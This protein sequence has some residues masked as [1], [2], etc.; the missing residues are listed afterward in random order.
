LLLAR[1]V[2]ALMNH[3]T[4]VFLRIE[5]IFNE[6]LDAPAEVRP[7][8][9]AERCDGDATLMDEVKSLLKASE[10]EEHV[11]ASRRREPGFME[12]GLE[13]ETPLEQRRIGPYQLDR[14]LGRGGMG[15]V[16]LAHRVDGQFEQKVAIKLIDL[17]LATDFFRERFRMERQILAGL[18][19]PFIARLLD[20][21][22][23]TDGDLYLAMEYVDG[24]PIHRYCETNK[25]TIAERLALFRNVCEAVQFAHQNLVVHRDLKPDNIF[26]AEDGTP[27]LLDFGTAKLVSPSREKEEGDLTR[28]GFQ[29]FT[30]QYASPEQVLG[31]PIT[32]ASDTYSL[33]VLLYL[34]LTGSVP[35]EL[36]E[37]STGEMVRV[38]CQEPPRKA[39][40]EVGSGKRL[41]PDLEAILDKALR[42]EPLER[43]RTAEQLDTDIQDFLEGRPV[44]A[45][46]GSF[47]YRAVKFVRRNRVGIAAAA[48]LAVTLTAGILGVVWQARVANEQRRKAEARSADLRALSN[49]LLSELDEAI[50]QIPGSTGAQKLLV[51]RVLEHLDRMAKDA[52]GDRQSELDLVDAYT[53]LGDVQGNVYDQN[54]GDPAG[55]LASLGKA[56]AIAEPLTRANPEDREALRALAAAQEDRGEVLGGLIKP[57]EAVESLKASVMNYDRLLALPG[58]TPAMFVEAARVNDTLADEEG[59]DSGLA[60]LPA[61]MLDYHRAMDLD[62]QAAKLDPNYV[63]AQKAVA[64]MQFKIGNAELDFDPAQA[65]RDLRVSLASLDALPE[66]ERAKL[67][68]VRLRALTLRK[69]GVALTEMEEFDEAW[70]LFDQA[71]VV[72]Q[73]IAAADSAD[74]KDVRALGD[75]KRLYF[76]VAS[77]NDWASDLQSAEATDPRRAHMRK[78][79]E[80]WQKEADVLQQLLKHDAAHQDWRIDLAYA[81]AR[82]ASIRQQ[83]HE[84][85]ASAQLKP[86]LAELKLFADKKDASSRSLF[87]A[88]TA[89]LMAEPESMRDPKQAQEW[90]ERGVAMTHRKELEW[91]LT[92]AQ[93]YRATGQSEKARATA[94][95]GLAL[96]PALQPGDPKSHDRKL[97]EAEARGVAT[98]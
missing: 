13:T 33:G 23:S 3:S 5:A 36:K 29:S 97:L 45:R 72:F 61:A 96:L 66:V 42:K 40:S 18:Q 46:R 58:A 24:V 94:Q 37:L 20:G 85:D 51:T 90:A 7:A 89:T 43:Y 27:R 80:I 14:L 16:Y 55:A 53:R 82:V 81:Q 64:H 76:D 84:G 25:L 65:L 34:L 63:Q 77:G 2:V 74:T 88:A 26:V 83:L 75:L 57:V 21:G 69:E 67:A 47:R 78:A 41:D 49:S 48:L 32:T 52:E 17:P 28:Q 30:P 44:A 71:L 35:Y 10:A 9:I 92:L 50:K 91:L 39:T 98:I 6:A 8:L 95:E 4:E 38:I 73:R 68:M 22:V 87:L 15:A 19:H 11:T 12:A 60:D 86:A 70:P 54:L 59:D 93:A 62:T 56:I 31:Q 79:A 1:G